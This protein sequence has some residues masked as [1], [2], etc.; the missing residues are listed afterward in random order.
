[1]FTYVYYTY[2]DKN[3]DRKNI[4]FF[5]RSQ[6][7]DHENPLLIGSDRITSHQHEIRIL[8]RDTCIMI[9]HIDFIYVLRIFDL[10]IDDLVFVER[11][12]P[13]CLN[14]IAWFEFCDMG[15][16]HAKWIVFPPLLARMSED[17]GRTIYAR[18]L[19]RRI[20]DRSKF[21]FFVEISIGKVFFARI[22][23]RHDW[24][25]DAQ[26]R[27]DEPVGRRQS[28]EFEIVVGEPVR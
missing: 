7:S 8:V 16:C 12:V 28:V 20:F 21:Q 25:I 14:H 15:E 24:V 10:D 9:L 3:Q 11:S 5:A 27:N 23:A 6:F 22:F 19:R 4:L 13:D 26:R 17:Q 18:L 2:H 1:M